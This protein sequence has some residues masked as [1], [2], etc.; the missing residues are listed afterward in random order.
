VLAT[1]VF[2]YAIRRWRTTGRSEM[3]W[4]CLGALAAVGYEP[5]GDF[6]VDIVYHPS[7]A[8]T[9]ISGFGGTIPLWTLF[10][11]V[12]FWAPGILYLTSQL[13]AGVTLKRWLSMFAVAVPITLAFE[14]P[15]LALGLYKYYGAQQPIQVLGYP[16][17]MAFSNSAVIFIVSLL[18][19]AA[20]KT[21]LVREKPAY[22]VLLVPSI[23]IGVGVVTVLPI[24]LGMSSTTSLV[25]I[26]LFAVASAAL[27]IAFV[28]IG[29]RL[30]IPTLDEEIP[31]VA[32]IEKKNVAS[33]I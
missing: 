27:S 4:M 3:F 19:H 11:Y 7:D 22:L 18:V 28:V 26:N 14:V 20:M 12:V 1:A 16:L 13:E 8:L 30:V 9:S 21:A 5:L 15:M 10:M 6:M 29:Y 24:G 2:G 33:S 23:I 31:E 32:E 17:W 25:I